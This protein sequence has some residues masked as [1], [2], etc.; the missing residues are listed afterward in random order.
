M[1]NATLHAAL[2]AYAEEAGDALGAETAAGA[3]VPFEVLEEGSRATPLY[4]Y[5]PRT[6]VFIAERSRLLA[7]LPSAPAARAALTRVEGARAHAR[8]LDPAA[9]PADA[10][11][12]ALLDSVYVESSGFNFPEERFAAAY[13]ALEDAL[14]Q[15]RSLCTVVVPVLGLELEGEADAVPLGDGISLLRAGA[16]EDAPPLP[17]AGKVLLVLERL[18]RPGQLDAAAE[19]RA[20]FGSVLT[21]LRLY[22]G[23][24]G[25]LDALAWAREDGAPWRPV[26]LGAGGAPHGRLVVPAGQEDELRA[27]CS[28]IARR[29]PRGG[30]L[31][32]ALARY[33]MAC[34]RPRAAEALTDV[35]LALRALLEPEGPASG[36]L[37]SRLAALCAAGPE[38]AEVAERV[39]HAASL[40]RALLAGLAPPDGQADALVEELAGHLRAILRDALCGHLDSDLRGVADDLLAEAAGAPA[41]A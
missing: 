31:A 26:A 12:A 21:A 40:E 41:A 7:R 29:A 22:D 10:I 3:E 24:T 36:R 6:D 35:L 39:A 8:R 32:W 20:A 16:L 13:A 38:R 25:A 15:G 34:E 28:L 27:F 30:E 18:G 23:A 14:Y 33:E 9:T 37:P 5:R 4:C 17:P 19:A 11:L 2:R 1:R